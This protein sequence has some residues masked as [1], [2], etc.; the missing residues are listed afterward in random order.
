MSP[1]QMVGGGLGALA[2]ITAGVVTVIL[3]TR[4]G[5]T[6]LVQPPASKQMVSQAKVDG[7]GP[8]Q[9]PKDLPKDAP[10]PPV[11]AP[12]AQ[13]QQPA[14]PPPQAQQPPPPQQPPPADQPPAP[15]QPANPPPQAQQPPPPQQP[16][17]ADQEPQRPPPAQPAP[18]PQN[19]PPAQQPPQQP[20]EAVQLPRPSDVPI[21]QVSANT[22]QVY[23]VHLSGLHPSDAKALSC[24]LLP[25]IARLPADNPLRKAIFAPDQ[26]TFADNYRSLRSQF[27]TAGVDTIYFFAE[28]DWIISSELPG[29]IVI[30]GTA[31]TLKHLV[32]RCKAS[33]HTDLAEFLTGF[34]PA[35]GLVGLRPAGSVKGWLV[36]SQGQVNEGAWSERKA[37]LVEHALKNSCSLQRASVSARGP[38]QAFDLNLTN[39]WPITL[40]NLQPNAADV[41]LGPVLAALIPNT[42][43]MVQL[44]GKAEAITVAPALVPYTHVRQIAHLSNEAD[45]Q[46]LAIATSKAF[47]GIV[48]RALGREDDPLKLFIG[49]FARSMVQVG[50]RGKDVITVM[51]P[52]VF[53]DLHQAKQVADKMR[54]QDWTA[55]RPSAGQHWELTSIPGS[56]GRYDVL[57][58]VTAVR[59]LGDNQEPQGPDEVSDGRA[60]YRISVEGGGD[61]AIWLDSRGNLKVEPPEKGRAQQLPAVELFDNKSERVAVLRL[62]I[63]PGN[64]RFDLMR[65]LTLLKDALKQRHEAE[66]R[67][68]KALDNL[69]DDIQKA[70][71]N[72]L[73]QQ[74]QP[75]QINWAQLQAQGQTWRPGSPMVG[76]PAMQAKKTA[77]ATV[78]QETTAI[79]LMAD[80]ER[81]IIASQ[82][83]FSAAMLVK[84]ADSAPMAVN[85]LIRLREDRRFAGQWLLDHRVLLTL[86]QDA[87]GL[88]NGT[89]SATEVK[90]LP[91]RPNLRPGAAQAALLPSQLLART[92]PR[93]L[94]MVSG[95]VHGKSL[96]VAFIDLKGNLVNGRVDLADNA[97]GGVYVYKE[98][99][100]GRHVSLKIQRVDTGL[101]DPEWFQ[102]NTGN[103]AGYWVHATQKVQNTIL[104]KNQAGLFS[105]VKEQVKAIRACVAGNKMFLIEIPQYQI[106]DSRVRE[107]ILSPDGQTLTIDPRRHGTVG[108][109]M[110][111]STEL[112]RREGN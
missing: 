32:E 31:D 61:L 4:P 19:P 12:E 48:D 47:N 5:A 92:V 104:T 110:I 44:L 76:S 50:T 51:K 95:Q 55:L 100:S 1:A 39:T 58:R 22:R 43:R 53:F 87:N 75:G 74:P 84:D 36:R 106:V 80:L 42:G 83:Q 98:V 66:K 81:K 18:A 103:F 25:I 24:A 27:L 86:Y 96:S 78:L 111:S 41:V 56:P 62:D 29:H 72:G 101:P 7:A 37:N 33:N 68:M 73:P 38:Q 102:G 2:I 8:L 108:F 85:P 90:Q 40:V 94:G 79:L 15:Q 10:N 60:R 9:A 64:P 6:E 99:N 91:Q 105:G 54:D 107:A 30:P 89:F 63:G 82:R 21:F 23:R 93:I 88:V 20:L 112:T 109:Q 77:E 57:D 70:R 34:R 49:A 52:P 45:A 28:A 16:P 35:R 65:S 59:R 17:P 67:A 46:E 3:A 71:L 26:A 97:L 14:N 11:Q 69:E 13:P